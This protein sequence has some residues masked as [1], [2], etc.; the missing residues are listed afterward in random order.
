M[1]GNFPSRTSVYLLSHVSG[2]FMNINEALAGE[3]VKES[4]MKQEGTKK[5]KME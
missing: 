5:K 4:E 3:K 2:V 1:S